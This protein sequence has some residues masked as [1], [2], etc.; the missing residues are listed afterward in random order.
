VTASIVTNSDG[1]SS[2]SLLS[3]KAGS[4]GTLT[5][6]SNILDTSNTSTSALAY[7][8][9]SDVSTLANLGISVSASDNGTLTYDAN[10]LDSVLNSDFS[11]VVG[12]FQ[13]ANSWGQSFTTLLNNAGSSS[14]TGALAL[15]SSSNSSIES[16]LNAEITKENSMI[17]A[18]QVSLT[19]ELNSANEI[20]QQLPSELQGVNELYSAITGYNQSSNG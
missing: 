8:N 17:S 12:F 19:A 10:S 2:L 5:V 11:G 20:M 13:D 4:A 9:S 16:T 3:I 18:E 1:S 7:T 15:A 14:P 6:T